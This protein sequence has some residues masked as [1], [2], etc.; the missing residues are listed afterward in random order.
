MPS[1]RIRIRAARPCIWPLD[2]HTADTL[3]SHLKRRRLA[4]G[5][6]QADVALTLGIHEATLRAW[7]G[8]ENTPAIRHVPKLIEFLGYDPYPAPAGL[9][10][11]L[12]ALRRRLGLTLIQMGRVIRVK[13]ERLAEWERGAG[14]PTG[15]HRGRVLELLERHG[16]SAGA[17]GSGTSGE[18]A[19]AQYICSTTED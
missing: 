5:L 13:A 14:E 15:R 17:A 9:P 2:P 18:I 8:S 19:Q 1:L 10:E 3:G 11:Q 16:L 6:L 12:L 7:E 4:L